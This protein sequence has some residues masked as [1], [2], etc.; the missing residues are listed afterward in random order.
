MKKLVTIRFI[1]IFLG[2]SL[3]AACGTAAMP[4]TNPA[5]PA[6]AAVAT[7][8]QAATDNPN[9]APANSNPQKAD[10]CTFLSKDEVGQVL[11]QPVTDAVSSGLGGVCTYTSKDA[12]VDLTI[13]HT[14]G[15]KYMQGM[16][17]K[18][19]DTILAV[20]GVGDSAVYNTFSSTLIFSK[21]DAAYLIG[22]SDL[23]HAM[24]TDD[25]QAKQKALAAVLL[26][27]LP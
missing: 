17:S 2:A 20:N 15:M 27:H 13:T 11:D 19:G 9:P 23:T 12:S 16:M 21:G 1:G 5:A 24:T 18:V 3:L 7:V 26:S 6:A 14:G 22:Y 4:T 25:I 8:A 10:A